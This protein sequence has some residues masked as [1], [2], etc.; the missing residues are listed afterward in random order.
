MFTK[1]QTKPWLPAAK[2]E[3]GFVLFAVN[4]LK[5]QQTGNLSGTFTFIL[6][7]KRPVLVSAHAENLFS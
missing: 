2:T 5:M 1:K 3:P 7:Q 4:K 6:P